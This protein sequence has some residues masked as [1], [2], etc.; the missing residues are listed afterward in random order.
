MPRERTAPF[1]PSG[2]LI[3]S[4]TCSGNLAED[5][6]RACLAKRAVGAKSAFTFLEQSDTAVRVRDGYGLACR[7]TVPE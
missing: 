7:A 3:F 1:Q 5:Q 6:F 4:N 2:T